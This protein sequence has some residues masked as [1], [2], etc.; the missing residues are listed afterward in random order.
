LVTRAA[1]G[2]LNRQPQH[3]VRLRRAAVTAELREPV[4]RS[5]NGDAASVW[6]RV[7][8]EPM[9]SLMG[10]EDGQVVELAGWRRCGRTALY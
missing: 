2:E 4:E 5:A 8:E 10:E 3:L 9:R 1:I 7:R 6:Q